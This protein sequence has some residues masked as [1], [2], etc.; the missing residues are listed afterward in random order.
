[1]NYKVYQ[2]HMSDQ[3]IDDLN[4]EKIQ[5]KD[6]PEFTYRFDCGRIDAD[7]V[8]LA[9][10]AWRTQLVKHCGNV[11]A[12]TPEG[13]FMVSNFFEDTAEN[14]AKIERLP[15]ESMS[16]MS[17]SDIIQDENGMLFVCANFGFKR[18]GD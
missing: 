9:D 2:A 18:F 5:Y 17:V 7:V 4:S 10:A 16:S 14:E 6:I 3:Q 1:M 11:N 8:T 15:N 12:E 13:A